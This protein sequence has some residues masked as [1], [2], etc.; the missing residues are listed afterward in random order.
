MLMGKLAGGLSV[1][2]HLGCRVVQLSNPFEPQTAT[3]SVSAPTKPNPKPSL[4]PEPN[5]KITPRR[6]PHRGSIIPVSPN[7]PNPNSHPSP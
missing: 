3:L 2:I 4:S 5:L 6:E 1:W 7:E